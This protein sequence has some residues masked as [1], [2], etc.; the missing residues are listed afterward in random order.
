[1]K[2]QLTTAILVASVPLLLVLLL[3][4]G[5]ADSPPARTSSTQEGETT[6]TKAF[7]ATPKKDIAQL[8]EA[9]NATDLGNTRRAV[10]IGIDQY[11]NL[12]DLRFCGKDVAALSGQ[13][14]LSG[15]SQE[16]IKV[17]SNGSNDAQLLPT[18]TNIQEQLATTFAAT[19]PGDLLLVVFSGHGV[20]VDGKSYLCPSEADGDGENA[21]TKTLLPLDWVYAAMQKTPAAVKMLLVDACQNVVEGTSKAGFGEKPDREELAKRKATREKATRFLRSLENPPQ[22]LLLLTACAPG[23]FSQESP[24]LGH[25]VYIHFLLRALAGHADTNGDGYVSLREMELYAA[26]ETEK[27]VQEKYLLL[28]RP[29]LHGTLAGNVIF[30]K[31]ALGKKFSI[32]DDVATLDEGV[33]RAAQDAVITLR[34]GK[35][36]LK[37]RIVVSKRVSIAGEGDNP[38]DVILHCLGKDGGLLFDADEVTLSSLSV[39]ADAGDAI[40]IRSGKSRLHNVV[41]STKGKSLD[42]QEEVLAGIKIIGEKSVPKI[43]NCTVK[44]CGSAGIYLADKCAPTLE[45]TNIS[46]CDP[47]IL[48][49]S[50]ARGNFIDCEIARNC[51]FNLYSLASE[52]TFSNCQFLEGA[53][54]GAFCGTGTK[55]LFAKCRFVNNRGHSISLTRESAPVFTGCHISDGARAGVYT[56][57]QAKGEFTNC[58]IRGNAEQNVLIESR[59]NP[60]FSKCRIFDGKEVGVAV[61]DEGLGT[62]DECVLH[63]N[64]LPNLVVAAKGHPKLNNSRIYDGG[65]DGVYVP[66][67]GNVTLNNCFVFN[68]A[69]E[70]VNISGGK[71]TLTDCN[72]YLNA[73]TGVQ[74]KNKGMATLSGSSV[75][76]SG[77]AEVAAFEG[78]KV[79]A[80]NCKIYYGKGHGVYVSDDGA[81]QFVDSKIYENQQAGVFLINGGEATLERC[82]INDGK[83]AGICVVE[84]GKG[85][86]E[87]ST[88]SGNTETAIF[89]AAGGTVQVSDCTI[90]KSKQGVHLLTGGNGRFESVTFDAISGADWKIENS[91]GKVEKVGEEGEE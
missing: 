19:Q 34:K 17:L 57:E 47:G 1:M 56:S 6:G 48:S 42:P 18:K 30:A 37:Q 12:P 8:G 21:D 77:N 61:F 85:V 29:T 74:V 87:K 79:K 82:Q 84:K 78:G 35:H 10:L 60:N 67:E 27:Y 40:T 26:R 49:V 15:F 25:G 45:R 75:Y 22:G 53:G 33:R 36:T 5:P 83:Q 46:N 59:S 91:A 24:D 44:N 66:D 72:I 62:F 71:A 64:K 89:A 70:G 52:S 76:S 81:A 43:S 32:P 7:F 2:N 90:A 4:C 68:N 88:L 41:V 50:G 86:V 9:L 55:G 73:S 58:D 3:G 38:E 20:R 31:C 11:S 69:R 16:A 28:Q 39:E 54:I 63:N 14:V 65:N 13:L 80:T 51:R 23:E